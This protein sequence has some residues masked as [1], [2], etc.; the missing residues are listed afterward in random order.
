MGC[1][2]ICGMLIHFAVSPTPNNAWRAKTVTFEPFYVKLFH[3]CADVS[4]RPTKHIN[5]VGSLRSPIIISDSYLLNRT[6]IYYIGLS[7]VISDSYIF[8]RTPTCY[9]GLLYNISD[10]YLLYQT[11]IYYIGLLYIIS[12]SYLLYRTPLYYI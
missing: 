4:G 10:S 3:A 12:D 2:R 5:V 6:P 7:L 8:Y 11:P 1:A 9:I